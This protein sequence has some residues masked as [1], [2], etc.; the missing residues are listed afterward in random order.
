MFKIKLL[1]LL[2]SC[3]LFA[4]C[5]ESSLNIE[6]NSFTVGQIESNEDG[7]KVKNFLIVHLD[8]FQLYNQQSKLKIIGNISHDA[9]LYITNIDNT[10]D[11]E[12]ISSELLLK[13]LDENNCVVYEYYE[14]LSQFYLFASS[15]KFK[16]NTEAIKKIKYDN[17]EILVKQ[18]I[19][20]VYGKSLVCKQK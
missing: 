5:V 15:E 19:N 7:L 6:E 18:F 3:F 16:S 12:N 1:I 2:F 13:I 9:D 10:S 20:D 11:R 4:S 8:S 17:S 14:T